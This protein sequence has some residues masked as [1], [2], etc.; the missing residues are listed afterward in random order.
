LKNNFSWLR[1]PSLIVYYSHVIMGHRTTR[2]LYYGWAYVANH[3]KHKYHS[4]KKQNPCEMKPKHKNTK[5]YCFLF[6]NAFS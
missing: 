4:Q 2:Q 6:F 5:T 1:F 3:T